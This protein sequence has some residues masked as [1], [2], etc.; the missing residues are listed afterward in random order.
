[1]ALSSFALDL[2]TVYA[3]VSASCCQSLN[4]PRQVYGHDKNYFNRIGT[5]IALICLTSS[6]FISRLP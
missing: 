6:P 1:M 2:H 3:T 5:V 4:L